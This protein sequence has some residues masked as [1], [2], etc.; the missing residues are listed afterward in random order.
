MWWALESDWTTN[1]DDIL[2]KLA[3]YTGEFLEESDLVRVLSNFGG[4]LVQR[5]PLVTP[6]VPL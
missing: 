5:A 2:V 6:N 3:L 4:V 1:F